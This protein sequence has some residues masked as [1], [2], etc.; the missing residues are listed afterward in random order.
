MSPDSFYDSEEYYALR[1]KEVIVQD[2]RH[3]YAFIF[4]QVVQLFKFYYP[5][6]KGLT[7]KAEDVESRMHTLF[8]EEKISDYLYENFQSIMKQYPTML[9][10]NLAKERTL[11]GADKQFERLSKLKQL[12]NIYIGDLC[13]ELSDVI[14]ASV[15]YA[16][17]AFPYRQQ[18]SR[19]S[20]QPY[21]RPHQWRVV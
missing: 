5:K 21:V 17:S 13:E 11:V 1:K 8:K 12:L 2:I 20:L 6:E 15:D 3:N 9:P 7:T 14:K 18:P 16:E 10:G 4:S 19:E